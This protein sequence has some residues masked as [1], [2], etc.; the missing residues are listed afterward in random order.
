LT[1]PIPHGGDRDEAARR[2]GVPSESLLDFSASVSPLPLPEGV[3]EAIRGSLEH[4]D[5]YPDLESRLLR[6]ALA[7]R[8]GRHED[9]IL[10]TSGATEA[11]SLAMQ[12]RQ[13][14]RVGIVGPC[15]RDVERAAGQVGAGVDF[16][17]AREDR[18]FVPAWDALSRWI[19]GHDVVALGSP[20]NPTGLVTDSGELAKAALTSPKTLFLLDEAFADFLETG[21]MT[22]KGLLPTNVLILRSMTKFWP[23]A[24]LR[25]GYVVGDRLR[26][27]ALRSCSAPWSVNAVAQAAGLACLKEEAYAGR[28]KSLIATE[29]DFLVK[30]LQKG[31]LRVYP[32]QA[33]F[34]LVFHPEPGFHKRL[35]VQH[36][37]LVR[38]ASDFPGLG[39]GFLRI[40]VRTR[41]E[42]T[43]LLEALPHAARTA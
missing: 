28:L 9:E 42:N 32:S 11:L 34:L 36:G 40:A 37:V 14:L 2:Y 21:S 35:A 5:R 7:F 22:A 15:Y 12:A 43:R 10:V 33:N 17:L 20:C 16:F 39:S 18:G 25:L 19:P 38:D 27:R 23:L 8:H 1:V 30:G 4:L 24:G 3:L 13:P 41:E 6:A 31:G 29:R 26:I